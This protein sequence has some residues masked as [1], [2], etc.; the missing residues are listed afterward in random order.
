MEWY[1]YIVF[2]GRRIE[3][4]CRN[5]KPQDINPRPDLVALTRPRIAGCLFEVLASFVNNRNACVTFKL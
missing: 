2:P 3:G 1:L 5:L 4:H